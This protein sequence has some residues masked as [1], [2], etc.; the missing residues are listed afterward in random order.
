MVVNDFWQFSYGVDS[1]FFPSRKTFLIDENG[2]LVKKIDSVDID[3]HADEILA[4]YESQS[5]RQRLKTK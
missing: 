5:P 2:V 1:F 4:L 3:K